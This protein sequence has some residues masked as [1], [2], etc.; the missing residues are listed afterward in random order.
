MTDT[1][2]EQKKRSSEASHRAAKA[3][4]EASSGRLAIRLR[5]AL[6]AA[7]CPV[8][9]KSWSPGVSTQLY[10]TKGGIVECVYV[11]CSF[12]AD[13]RY[14]MYPNYAFDQSKSAIY[15]YAG[16]LGSFRFRARKAESDGFS[17][18]RINEIAEAVSRQLD[19]EIATHSA[20]VELEAKRLEVEATV[21]GFGELPVRVEH[22]VKY[23]GHV[24][25][26]LKMTEDQFRK[27]AAELP[28]FL[29]EVLP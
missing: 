2:F 6:A 12:K 14:A 8:K 21:A 29:K 26:T 4:T 5:A 24:D 11:E 27:V 15:F 23:K 25:L 18:A 22:S 9:E 13:S 17:D 19:S 20:N 7:G 28:G 3:A 16:R 1:S 10:A